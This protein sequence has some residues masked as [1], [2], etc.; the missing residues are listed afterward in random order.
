MCGVQPDGASTGPRPAASPARRAATARTEVLT[1]SCAG[2]S[3]TERARGRARRLASP[4][5]RYSPH[6]GTDVIMCGVQPDG[7]STGPRAASPARR[8]A[9]AR[10]EVLTSSSRRSEH[11]AARRRLASPARRYSPHRGTDV[12]MC[13]VQPDGASTGPRAAAS[14]ARRAAT[15]R[16]EVLTSSCAGC[17]PTERA[18]A[19]RRRLASPARRYSPHRGTDV[20]MCGVQPDGASTGARAPLQPAQRY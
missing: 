19:A 16:T 13:G 4:A 1:S 12:I 15:A 5:R 8:A 3:P 17:S 18:R 14:P 2:C 20:I 10:T 6:R 9:T 11:G 7:A